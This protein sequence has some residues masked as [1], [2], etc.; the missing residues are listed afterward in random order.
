MDTLISIKQ[1][2]NSH[3]R[4]VYLSIHSNNFDTGLVSQAK[5][6]DTLM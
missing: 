3:I 6:F 1:D 5:M 4:H 2:I